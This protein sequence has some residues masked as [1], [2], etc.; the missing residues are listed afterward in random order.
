MDPQRR[1]CR[2][3]LPTRLRR[4]QIFPPR[5]TT[6]ILH[7]PT[8]LKRRRR[9]R[10][11][12][13]NGRLLLRP[14]IYKPHLLHGS[15]ATR[16]INIYWYPAPPPPCGGSSPLPSSSSAQQQPS[17]PSTNSILINRPTCVANIVHL[18]PGSTSNMHNTQ[19]TMRLHALAVTTA[20]VIFLAG[21]AAQTCPT[22]NTIVTI[23]NQIN[24]FCVGRSAAVY[25][26]D[27]YIAYN[28]NTS[29]DWTNLDACPTY[30]NPVQATV[31]ESDQRYVPAVTG[32]LCACSWGRTSPNKPEANF[33]TCSDDSPQGAPALPPFDRTNLSTYAFI[34]SGPDRNYKTVTANE[35]HNRGPHSIVLYNA[36]CPSERPICVGFLD[37]PNGQVF[38]SLSPYLAGVC[39]PAPVQ[40]GN[41]TANNG[42]FVDN[43]DDNLPSTCDCISRNIN[44]KKN[45][46]PSGQGTTNVPNW[47]LA[48]SKNHPDISNTSSACDIVQVGWGWDRIIQGEPNI[49]LPIPTGPTQTAS[50]VAPKGT[51]VPQGGSSRKLV[52]CEEPVAF[53]VGSIT[54]SD[55]CSLHPEGSITNF[56]TPQ[57]YDPISSLPIYAAAALCR[58]ESV[59]ALQNRV[60]LGTYD[61]SPTSKSL[62]TQ[63]EEAPPHVRPIHFITLVLISEFYYFKNI[64]DSKLPSFHGSRD[65]PSKQYPD[66]YIGTPDFDTFVATQF[67]GTISPFVL[68]LYHPAT[69]VI[70]WG[71]TVNQIVSSSAQGA[72]NY[73]LVPFKPG[74]ES[75]PSLGGTIPAPI[76]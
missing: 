45:L 52:P 69:A 22:K 11:R 26:M 27:N 76:D 12:T 7:P 50:V 48:Y 21:V 16:Q 39:Q 75:D 66:T 4:R 46:L 43:S 18:Y 32:K 54:L 72:P 8:P 47:A 51:G 38:G 34:A 25:S 44:W 49:G 29:T 33:V 68:A 24:F 62:W 60:Y 5:H 13:R 14:D 19:P 41:L 63:L 20:P 73:T 74:H 53:P 15:L 56:S 65:F 35:I 40:I 28:S 57:H 61:T 64:I 42:Y 2:T 30:S 1:L 71:A 70:D 9:R 31:S 59:P 23:G 10:A 67:N 6:R 3:V 17:T 36:V 55:Y 37:N 58:F